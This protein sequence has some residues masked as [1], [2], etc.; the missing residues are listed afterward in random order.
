MEVLNH[1][2]FILNVVL[3]SIEIVRGST[4]IL[5]LKIVRLFFFLLG[6]R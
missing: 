2:V 6:Y 3:D 1:S 4:E 5:L